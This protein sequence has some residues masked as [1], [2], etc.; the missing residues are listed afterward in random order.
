M[1]WEFLIEL[2]RIRMGITGGFFVSRDQCD[3]FCVA[4]GCGS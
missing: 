4:E 3:T 2:P 1:R